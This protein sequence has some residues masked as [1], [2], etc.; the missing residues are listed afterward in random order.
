ML[1]GLNVVVVGDEMRANEPSIIIMNHRTRLDWLYFWCALARQ[2]S[3][4]MTEKIMLKAPLKHIP[5]PG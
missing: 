5:G 3:G 2:P 4:I 1:I